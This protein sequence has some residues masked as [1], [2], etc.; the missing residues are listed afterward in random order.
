[1]ANPARTWRCAFAGRVVWMVTVK[2]V[3][4]WALN[5]VGAGLAERVS[6][7]ER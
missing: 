4:T 6:Y 7:V 5:P 1:M 2:P 3:H